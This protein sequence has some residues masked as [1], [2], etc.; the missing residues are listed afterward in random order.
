MVILDTSIKK[1]KK[2]TKKKEKQ[3][4]QNGDV[5]KIALS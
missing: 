5:S 4:F 3:L 2:E 1:Y